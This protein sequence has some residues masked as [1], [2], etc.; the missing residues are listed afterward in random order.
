MPGLRAA[1]AARLVGSPVYL[2]AEQA[3]AAA[4]QF[5]ETADYRAWRFLAVAVMANHVH[6][7]VGVPGDPPSE[8]LVRDFKSY[9]GRVLNRGWG[10]RPGGTW[11]A[12]GGGSRRKLPDERAVRA[13]VRYVRDQE[14]PLVVWADPEFLGED[15]LGTG[16][17]SSGEPS[18]GEPG[19]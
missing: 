4:G 9:A 6:L 3:T 16:G 13:A 5:R 12:A 10:R 8:D 17:P 14:R 19:A 15:G 1:S 2:T 11:W 18:S 7:V